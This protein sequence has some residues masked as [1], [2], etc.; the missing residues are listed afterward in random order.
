[1]Q[2]I[3]DPDSDCQLKQRAPGEAT[4][5]ARLFC[6][7]PVAGIGLGF[8]LTGQFFNIMPPT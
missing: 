8:T 5:S 1:M 7:W 6:E 2:S 4:R 3:V